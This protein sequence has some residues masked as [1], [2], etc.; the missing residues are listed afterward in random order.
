MVRFPD[1]VGP[2]FDVTSNNKFGKL[3]GN[4]TNRS[5]MN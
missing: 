1:I 5:H 4:I 2:T 3:D